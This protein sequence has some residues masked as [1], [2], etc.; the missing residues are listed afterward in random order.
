MNSVIFATL[1]INNITNPLC[2]S[3]IFRSWTPKK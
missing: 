3:A 1:P 2:F